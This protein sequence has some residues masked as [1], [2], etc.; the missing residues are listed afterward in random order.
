[1]S[2]TTEDLLQQLLT[3]VNALKE[4]VDDLKTAK[5]DEEGTHPPPL[6]NVT[7]T[8]KLVTMVTT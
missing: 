5:A 7:A 6:Q 4:D 8:V 2:N 1:M 3:K